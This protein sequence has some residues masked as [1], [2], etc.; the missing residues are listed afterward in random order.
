MSK[1]TGKLL[2][3]QYHSRLF[4]TFSLFLIGVFGQIWILQYIKFYGNFIA[5]RQV[6]LTGEAFFDVFKDKKSPFRVSTNEIN[7]EVLGT[8]FN[9]ASYE[10]ENNVEVV[11]EEGKLVFNSG[12]MNKSYTMRPNDLV[13]YDKDIKNYSTEVVQPYKYL[14]W[15]E[16]QLVSGN[17]LVEIERKFSRRSSQMVT[18]TS[19]KGS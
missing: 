18:H 2:H 19:K 16:G 12:E 1:Y 14:S 3:Y 4:F 5:D 17:R 10:D 15:T 11:P 7:V 8:R 6:T 9:I 13:I